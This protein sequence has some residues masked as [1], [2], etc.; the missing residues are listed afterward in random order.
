MRYQIESRN[1][2]YGVKVLILDGPTAIAQMA[3]SV[4]DRARAERIVAC[5]NACEGFTDSDLAHELVLKETKYDPS[6]K[7]YPERSVST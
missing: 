4:Q 2:G 7:G 6:K 3:G 5:L 1:E